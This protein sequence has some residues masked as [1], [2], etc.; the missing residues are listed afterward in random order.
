MHYPRYTLAPG[1]T[2]TPDYH[3]FVIGGMTSGGESGWRA[4]CDRVKAAEEKK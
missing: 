1:E 3:P 4:F 2:W